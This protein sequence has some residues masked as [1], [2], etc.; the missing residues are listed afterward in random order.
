[1]PGRAPL[2]ST[3]PHASQSQDDALIHADPFFERSGAPLHVR[4]Q[5]LGGSFV[6][7]SASAALIDLV[8]ATYGG[9]PTDGSLCCLPEFQIELRLVRRDIVPAN[10]PPSVRMQSGA[11][12]LCGVMDSSNCVVLMPEQRKA[13]IVA[14][15]DMLIRP[16]HL[17][18]ELIEFAV[19]TLATRGMGLVPLHGACVGRDG[20]G[21]LLLGASGAGKSTLALQSMLH[22]LDFLAED[23]VFVSPDPLMA[24]GVPNYLHVKEDTLHFVEDA[25]TRRWIRGSQIIR[26]RSG[27][28]K[29]EID[30]RTHATNVMASS[31]TLVGAVFLRAQEQDT[32]HAQLTRLSSD[33]AMKRLAADQPYAAGQ[34]GWH[35]FASQILHAGVYELR[36]GRH[37]HDALDALAPLL[38]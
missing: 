34:P 29:F 15:E 11:G 23:G 33:D 1:V 2:E 24:R 13:L 21:V 12:F 8:D 38:A 22:G 20:R 37:P 19:F 25:D 14:S 36:R 30:V 16:Y 4:K 5:I 31:L 6:F 10:E 17:R 7:K 9:L 32:P 26:R 27:V 28:E 18:Y 35:A 3:W